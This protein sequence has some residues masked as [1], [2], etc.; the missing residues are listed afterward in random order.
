MNKSKVNHTRLRVRDYYAKA[1]KSGCGCGTSGCCGGNES[2]S[3]SVIGQ[4]IGYSA[5]EMAAVPEGS[6]LGLGCGNPQAIAALKPGE[7]VVD[8]G[9]GAG[10]DAFLAARRVG[11]QGR[12]IGVDMTPEMLAKARANAEKTGLANTEFRE[13]FLEE[14]PIDDNT[15][16]VIIS[17][18][19]IN[20]SPDKQ[21]VFNE[22]FRILKPG[23]R[24][25]VSDVVASVEIPVHM[26][27][28]LELYSACISGASL[29]ADLEK[30]M[31]TAGFKDIS[32]EPKEESRSFIKEWAPGIPVTDYVVSAV[33]QAVKP[34]VS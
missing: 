14:L 25:A 33:I 28:D 19:V 29:I 20:L 23:G 31:R 11:P 9:S 7:T 4:A 5:V 6:N 30:M 3:A 15:A 34:K 10:F 13:G 27:K 1:A 24:L 32:I 12:V 21:A 26:K 16:D 18:C 17:N 2:A 8:L 22:A